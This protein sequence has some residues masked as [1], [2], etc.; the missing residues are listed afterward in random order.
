MNRYNMGT[1]EF[2]A[3]VIIQPRNNIIALMSRGVARIER[4]FET[5]QR[6]AYFVRPPGEARCPGA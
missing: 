3:V 1:Y 5:I 2:I 6:N 4:N